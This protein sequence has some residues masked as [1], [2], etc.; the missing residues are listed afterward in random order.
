M[1]TLRVELKKLKS[2]YL[3]T[4]LEMQMSNVT[5]VTDRNFQK[6]SF[7]LEHTLVTMKFSGLSDE[8]I[9]SFIDHLM[10]ALPGYIQVDWLIMERLNNLDSAFLAAVAREDYQSRVTGEIGF[11]WLVKKSHA[12]EEA[13]QAGGPN[14]TAP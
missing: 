12:R 14:G 6:K 13:P 4:K 1:E 10:K 5:N 8:L 2:L 9:F 7:D 11:H 3:L